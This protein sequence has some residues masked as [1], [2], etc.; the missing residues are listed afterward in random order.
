LEHWFYKCQLFLT[1]LA[2]SG[3]LILAHCGT[4]F[5]LGSSQ[6]VSYWKG[7]F[8]MSFFVFMAVVVFLGFCL[9]LVVLADDKHKNE[10]IKAL[11]D[12][13]KQFVKTIKK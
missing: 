2:W 9:T 3:K 5:V 4:S 12:V 7:E 8:L 1:Q 13:T 10:A 6:H 11:T